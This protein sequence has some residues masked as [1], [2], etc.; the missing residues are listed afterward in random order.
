MTTLLE[1]YLIPN[2]QGME[3]SELRLSD[4]KDMDHPTTMECR[5]KRQTERLHAPP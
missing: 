3:I 5:S 4:Y 2:A 1:N